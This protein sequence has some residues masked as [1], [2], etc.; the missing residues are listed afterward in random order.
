MLRTPAAVRSA[1]G[2]ALILCPPLSLF[3]A[4]YCSQPTSSEP[5]LVQRRLPEGLAAS[6]VPNP[7]P[8]PASAPQAT[9]ERS[10]LWMRPPTTSPPRR[11]NA[12]A[13]SPRSHA[14]TPPGD[15]PGGLG[16]LALTVE[17]GMEEVEDRHVAGAELEVVGRQ[18]VEAAVAVVRADLG[19]DRV[20][21][22]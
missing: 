9:G 12:F 18:R 10:G 13:G 19:E 4:R 20:Q 14:A 16:Q 8:N 6:G 11:I 17:V 1:A 15:G 5:G 3:R 22:P 2:P 7:V 21:L